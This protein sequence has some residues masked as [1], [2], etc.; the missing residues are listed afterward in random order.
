M[1]SRTISH[2]RLLERI[3]QDY[4]GEIYR[5]R[6]QRLER[7]VAVRLLS[8]ERATR[9]DERERF[10]REAHIASLVSHPH[11]CAVH[12]SGEDAGQA[13]VVCELLE[14]HLLETTLGGGALPSERVIELGIQIVDALSALH[15]RGI[16]HGSLD[17]SNVFVTTDGHV[18]LL[19]VGRMSALWTTSAGPRSLDGSSPTTSIDR[20]TPADVSIAQFRPTQAPEVVRGERLDHTADI[21]AA[22]AILYHMAA[23]RPA[24]E[25][26]TPPELAAAIV[27]GSPAP[28]HAVNPSV[29]EGLESV[30]SRALASERGARYQS[31]SDFLGDLRRLRRRA[32]LSAT[33]G[34]GAAA[35]KDRRAI[36]WAV[37]A[38]LGIVL[39]AAGVWWTWGVTGAPANRHTLLVG[40]VANGTNDP[41][42]DGTLREA[43]TVHLGQSP[44]LDLV[45]DERLRQI[46]RMMGRNPD[47]ALTHE[48]AREACQRLGASAMLDGS[49]S[50][51]GRLT[52]VA[53]VATDC[54]TGE[55]IVRDQVEVERKEQVL[56]SLG[57]IASSMRRSLGESVASLERHNVTI[58]EATTGSLEALRSYTAGTARRAAGAEIESIPFFER[59]IALDPEFALAYTTLSS[60]YGGLGE[61]GR[62]EEYARLAYEHR[63]GVSERERLFIT[64]QY[65]DR[66]TGDQT[67]AREALEV[68]TRSYPR[69]Y[70]PANALAVLLIRLGDYERAI[71][72]AEEAS[73][74]NPAHGFPYSNL[75]YACRGAGRYADARAAAE[76]AVALGIETLPTR[77]LLYQLAE[78]DGNPAEA[79][80]HLAWGRER[81]RGFD[82]TGA[83]AQVAAFR[84]RMSEAREL[85]AQTVAAAGRNEFAQ[86]GT[87]YAAQAA[88]TEA[89]YGAFP[90]A[91]AQARQ[92]PEA[93]T[94]APRARAA[95]A[96]A[97]AGAMAEAD[98]IAG[99]LG[100][101]RPDDTLLHTAY[102]PVLEAALLWR[103]GRLDEALT[104]LR[105]AA[106]YEWGS[107]AALLPTYFR[108]L[109]R[110]SAR[111][112]TE[113]A[114][115]FRSMIEHRGVDPFS[116]VI[117]LAHLGLA[118][119][120]AA[121]GDADGSRAA[122][123]Q[124]LAIW[125]DADADVPVIRTARQ[126][127]AIAGSQPKSP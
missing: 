48:A 76:R 31:A 7:D 9:R 70:R 1:P 73:R 115:D 119:A 85:F 27:R 24:Y 35:G 103:R 8:P 64:Y 43:L 99:A 118:R 39:A 51:V 2:Y 98:A 28:V 78:M 126:E 17:P 127:A 74:R 107:V 21:F 54:A 111:R 90:Q 95:T 97:L 94:Y 124:V 112:F 66:V 26:D 19:D 5:A 110:L 36:R 45:S 11:V 4:T 88:L 65:H 60:L 57:R 87:G 10:R 106:S 46:L 42:F 12:D 52:I 61:T 59:A 38:L 41:D 91:I 114:A 37:P 75:A 56:G 117:P 100:R 18:K 104:A 81:A 92:V 84:G 79:E 77:R 34:A 15:R 123:G 121:S 6:D 89:L 50:A 108:G 20:T 22:G 23:G 102:L 69:D 113:A 120:L 53:L 63:D 122:Y 29:P 49:V 109:T 16:V 3:G 86:T 101:E 82:L 13:F 30:V 116:P 67:R 58:E 25:A 83:Q 40:S 44:F 62:G 105:P 72:Q 125:K 55:T 71:A 32:E 96:L 14:G 68:W 80:R 33:S 47:A 93:T